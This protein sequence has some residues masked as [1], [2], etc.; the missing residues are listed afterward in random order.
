M[1]IRNLLTAIILAAS[2]ALYAG[3][4]EA[5]DWSKLRVGVEGGNEGEAD[6]ENI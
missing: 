4:A 2:V 3:I 1:K 5:K 6:I